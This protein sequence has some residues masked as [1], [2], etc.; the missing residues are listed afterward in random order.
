MNRFLTTALAVAVLLTASPVS[1]YAENILY[2]HNGLPSVS[3]EEISGDAD[4]NG[5]F[6]MAD[7]VVLESYLLKGREPENL[8]IFDFNLDGT[9]DVFDFAYM[10]KHLVSKGKA[11]ARNYE[12]NIVNSPSETL[13][14]VKVITDSDSLNDYLSEFITDKSEILTYT[15]KY[16][17]EFFNE[18]NLILY[19]MLQSRGRGIFYSI[20]GVRHGENGG[21]CVDIASGYDVYQPLYQITNTTILFQVGISKLQCSEKDK[22]TINDTTATNSEISTHSYLSPDGTKELYITQEKI[23]NFCDVR[24]YLR[25]RENSL[26]PLSYANVNNAFTPFNDNGKW[27]KDSE[28]NNVFGDGENF[29][30]TWLDDYVIIEHETGDGTRDSFELSLE[31]QQEA[32]SYTPLTL[33]TIL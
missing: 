14:N 33:P 7:A 6:N 21:I 23:M 13:P 2:T 3:I 11:L 27:F 4:G 8:Q 18:N 28:G 15:E 24:I 17:D 5:E 20:E 32:V 31:P 12:I 16:S 26:A 22:I 10:R 25:M 30:I 9:V 19:P 29:S 1:A